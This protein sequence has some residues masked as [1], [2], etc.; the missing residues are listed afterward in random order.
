MKYY[1]GIDFG[2]TNIVAG[3]VDETYRILAK[4]RNRTRREESFETI[5]ADIADTA[6]AAVLDAGMT[7][8]DMESVGLGAPGSISPQTNKLLYNNNLNW[9]NVPLPDEMASHFPIPVLIR[10]DADCAALGE[11][12]AGAAN[13]YDHVLMLTLGTGVGGGIIVNKK[14]FSG[15][16][17]MGGEIGHTKLIFGGARCT[18]GQLGC[19][20]AYASATALIRQTIEAMEEHP[21]SLLSEQC[22]GDPAAVDAQTA[23]DAARR[24][25][26]T[27]QEVVDRFITYLAAGISSLVA[28]IRPQIVVI[29]GG[30]SNEREYLLTPLNQKLKELTYSAA[31]AGVPPVVCAALGND[32]GI[33]GAAML[34]RT[35][36]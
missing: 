21:E 13:G 22:G 36:I 12:L 34:G 15:C 27:A 4:H 14:I 5:V 18:C 10:N 8:R 9:Y 17:R 1:L 6:Y 25:D 2:G 33:V 16:D 7:I 28:V 31:Q 29:G 24:G 19:L 35:Q 30:I 32:T 26:R 23:F 3:V 11:A 20:E